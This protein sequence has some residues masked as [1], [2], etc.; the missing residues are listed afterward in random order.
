MVICA[1]GGKVAAGLGGKVAAG[2][3]G[4]VGLAV[5]LAVAGGR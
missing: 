2:L 4:N 1:R 5:A 3:G